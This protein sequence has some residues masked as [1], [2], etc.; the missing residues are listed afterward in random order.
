MGKHKHIGNL[1][2]QGWECTL[3]IPCLTVCGSAAAQNTNPALNPS[4]ST[5]AQILETSTAQ[6]MGLNKKS[7][8]CIGLA[9]LDLP[10]FLQGIGSVFSMMI[11]LL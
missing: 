11:A 7:T 6:A 4:S 3:T 2:F 1:P 10:L 5:P 8:S 9:V